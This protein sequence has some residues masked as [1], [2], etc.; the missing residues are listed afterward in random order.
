MNERES[1]RERE[2]DEGGGGERDKGGYC[3]MWVES[4]RLHVYCIILIQIFK[5]VNMGLYNF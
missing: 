4:A 3:L 2:R 1:E 5:N